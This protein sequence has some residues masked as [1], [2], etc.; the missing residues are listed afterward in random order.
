MVGFQSPP[1]R[2]QH[3]EASLA[4]C[5]SVFP[6]HCFCPS[7]QLH[8]YSVGIFGSGGLDGGD[9]HMNEIPLLSL[10]AAGTGEGVPGELLHSTE[11]VQGRGKF[12][13]CN[14][15]SALCLRTGALRGP[16]KIPD[17]L[18]SQARPVQ[19]PGTVSQDSLF[20]YSS[21]A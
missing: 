21:I 6:P 11:L 8:M 17:S 7:K 16:G 9:L 20:Q 5:P 18:K 2:A 3:L 15:L 14:T 4:I 13:N 1:K 19:Q 10:Q 12:L